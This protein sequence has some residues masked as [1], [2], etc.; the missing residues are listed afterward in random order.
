M[1]DH[2]PLNS[3]QTAVYSILAADVT[4]VALGVP[5]FDWVEEN[6]GYPYVTLGEYT[7][8]N[9]ESKDGSISEV[10]MELGCWSSSR[11]TK[12]VN[13]IMNAVAQALTTANL[14]LSGGYRSLRRG[15]M[16]SA[17]AVIAEDP[18]GRIIRHGTVQVGWL[19]GQV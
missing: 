17:S 2:I 19:V 18:N 7:Q 1:S 15:F 4:L 5:V 11:N 9:D 13:E 14:T 12:Q 6:Q 3:V 10:V 8:E 16:V